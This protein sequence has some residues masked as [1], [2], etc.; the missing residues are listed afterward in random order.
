MLGGPETADFRRWK[1]SGPQSERDVLPKVARHSSDGQVYVTY[2][3]AGRPAEIS[4]TTGMGAV[5][6]FDESGVLQRV[7]INGSELAAPW[8]IALAPASFGIFGGDLL[9]ATSA[10]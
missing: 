7:L 9:V 1:G 8:G 5:A 4:A 10:L 3:P 6:I 2:A